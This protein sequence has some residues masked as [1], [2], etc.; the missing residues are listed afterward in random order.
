MKAIRK[1]IFVMMLFSFVSAV[2]GQVKIT[3]LSNKGKIA[4]L[5]KGGIRSTPYTIKEIP[6]EFKELQAV[7]VPRGNSGKPGTG[8]SFKT[9]VAVTIYLLVDARYK[10][11]KLK[12]WKKT[13]LKAIWLAHKKPYKDIIYVKDFPAGVIKIVANPAG[14]IP[15]MAVIKKK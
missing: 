3:D 1:I 4:S 8:Y 9:D 5:K 14:C 7:Y 12:G 11:L 2:F 6:V 15:H 10:Q 13:A